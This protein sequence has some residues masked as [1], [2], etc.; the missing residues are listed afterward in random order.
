MLRLVTI[1][2][3]LVYPGLS[4]GLD[5]DPAE[6]SLRSASRNDVFIVEIR[7]SEA[8]PRIGEMHT[9]ILKLLTSEEEPVFPANI[10]I[11]GGMDGHSHGLPTQ[12]QA[13]AYGGEG[14]YLID[15]VRFNM[16]GLWRL[17]FYI[18]TNL[19]TDIVDFEFEVEF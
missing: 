12:P 13:V 18:E 10:T 7:P 4:F 17:S 3:L 9:W 11:G 8:P 6:W 14:E 15:G 19:G 5:T 2:A 1:T 16:E